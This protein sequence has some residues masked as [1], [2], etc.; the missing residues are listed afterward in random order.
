MSSARRHP[1]NLRASTRAQR[2]SNTPNPT[3]APRGKNTPIS[4]PRTSVSQP[5]LSPL[6]RIPF[7]ITEIQLTSDAGPVTLNQILFSTIGNTV[8]GRS[9]YAPDV[10]PDTTSDQAFASVPMMGPSIGKIADGFHEYRFLGP[11]SFTYNPVVPSTSAG[12]MLVGWSDDPSATGPFAPSEIGSLN[13][14][15]RL[16]TAVNDR[17]SFVV[18]PQSAPLAFGWKYIRNNNSSV[19]EQR[20]DYFGCL[21]A[22]GVGLTATNSVY[23]TLSMRGIIEFRGNCDLRGIGQ[24]EA[25]TDRKSVV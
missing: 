14:G 21:M 7:D 18:T 11:V 2:P 17:A 3:R 20:Q 24:P 5:V 12:Q 1:M 13:K 16:A 19:A 15:H 4:R 10:G 8:A 23:G 6:C 22:S 9:S 25:S